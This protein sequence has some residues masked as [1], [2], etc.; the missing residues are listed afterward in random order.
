MIECRRSRDRFEAAVFVIDE[1]HAARH[2]GAEILADGAED[3]DCAAGHVFARIGARAFDDRDR[4]GIAHREAFAGETGG[5]E[6]AA[7]C[8]IEAGVADDG[9]VAVR[10]GGGRSVMRPPE[11]PLPT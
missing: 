4:A 3:H 10:L 11:R 9:A 8:A 5:E 2:A 6:F 1:R 7:G